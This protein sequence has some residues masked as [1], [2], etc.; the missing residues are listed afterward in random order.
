MLNV[1]GKK[2]IYLTIA[3]I[4]VGSSLAAITTWGFKPGIDFTGGT[5]WQI[6]IPGSPSADIVAQTVSSI[7]GFEDAKVTAQD[8]GASYMIRF[9]ETDENGHNTLKAELASKFPGFQELSYQS[10]GPSVSA[11]LKKNSYTA[12]V[13]VLLGI[14]LYIAFAFRQV[15]RPVSS[16][17]YGFITLVSLFHDVAVPAGL[18][19]VLGH[20]KG[21]EIDT[22]FIV[23]L[24]V[25]MGF[26]VHD[27]IVV[28]DRIRE[29]L[30][31]DRGRHTFAETI[32]RS[33]TQTLAR[34]INTSLTLVFV[35]VALYFAG[36]ASLKYFMLTLLVGTITGI[37]SSVFV[38]S[39]L[40]HLAE[41][42]KKSPV[43][44]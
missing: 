3:A 22:N 10:I 1:T 34:S 18:L 29:N 36:P 6:S 20:L 14:S 38:A 27:T 39:P 28:F 32:N 31:L 21:V 13:L 12:I 4:L 19:S 41:G 30:I 9:K 15:S 37:Y 17:T 33:V 5:M 25:V 44:K 35:L 11:E 2:Y 40:L 24:L 8:N 7:K 43:K 16:W 42:S 26:S 23:A